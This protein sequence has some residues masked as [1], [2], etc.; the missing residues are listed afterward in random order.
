MS[1]SHQIMLMDCS[2]SY[3]TAACGVLVIMIATSSPIFIYLGY[4]HLVKSC[5]RSNS[6]AGK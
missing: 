5:R 2:A 6:T 4:T 1:D 3:S